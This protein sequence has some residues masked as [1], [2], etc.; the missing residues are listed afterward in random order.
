MSAMRSIVSSFTEQIRMFEE[1]AARIRSQREKSDDEFYGF[2][3]KEFIRQSEYLINQLREEN[4]YNLILFRM[5]S[6]IEHYEISNL[7]RRKYWDNLMIKFR[8]RLPIG[9]IN[10]KHKTSLLYQA[11][12]ANAPEQIIMVLIASSN[13]FIITDYVHKMLIAEWILYYYESNQRV[14]SYFESKYKRRMPSRPEPTEITEFIDHQYSYSI[15]ELITNAYLSVNFSSLSNDE[16]DALIIKAC[17]FLNVRLVEP[18]GFPSRHIIKIIQDNDD[19]IQSLKFKF[20]KV[21]NP[22][23]STWSDKIEM[24]HRQ[25]EISRIQNEERLPYIVEQCKRQLIYN[26]FSYYSFEIDSEKVIFM[27]RSDVCRYVD[28]SSGETFI[29]WA[30]SVGL[31]ERILS[32]IRRSI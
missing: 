30:E 4:Y 13:N 7:I 9:A 8:S 29:S 32:D 14:I 2:C 5:S 22:H 10:Y 28:E 3:E 19:A 27:L 23:L 11:I 21:I 6:I 1:K 15:N 25:V 31:P 20:M 17:S 24:I 12:R 26:P 18:D 16:K